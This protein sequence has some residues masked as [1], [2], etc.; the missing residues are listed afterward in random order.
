MAS[1]CITGRC[2][3]KYPGITIKRVSRIGH[4]GEAGGSFARQKSIS[5]CFAPWIRRP[6]YNSRGNLYR[7][8][9]VLF[10]ITGRGWPPERK[11]EIRTMAEMESEAIIGEYKAFLQDKAFPCVG[12]R[13]A[14]ARQH[15]RSMVAGHMGCPKDDRAI[16]QFLYHFVD[17]YRKSDQLF[18]SA[19]VIF[20]APE[21]HSEEIFDHCLWQRL[22]A[23]GH[24]RRGT[25]RIRPARGHPDPFFP[26]LQ[27][28]SEGRG[29]L[30][31]RPAPCQQQTV[32]TI[33]VSG[34]G[35]QS[36]CSI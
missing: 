5:R 8:P 36:P 17:D 9:S 29:V 14:L 26:E 30:H 20:K 27:L 24:A 23:L 1:C 15:I 18:H 21:M 33:P 31:H 28:Q 35:L 11:A 34:A 22:Q 10:P 12:A 16:L 7:S 2:S 32:A 3:T 19:A 13:A 4:S 25:L 6:S